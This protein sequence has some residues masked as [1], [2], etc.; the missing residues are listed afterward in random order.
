MEIQADRRIMMSDSEPSLSQ[1]KKR[2]RW[3][4]LVGV[5][6]YDDELSFA[7]LTVCVSDAIR[8]AEQLA[9][10]GF[11]R[12][13]I[14]LLTDQQ[15]PENWPVYEHIL[16]KLA[17][18]ADSTEEEDLLL[19]YFSGHGQLE[20]E[21]GDPYVIPRNGRGTILR[22]T[23]VAVQ[24][25]KELLLKARAKQKVIILDACHSGADDSRKAGGS[26][27]PGFIERV[28]TSAEGL[29][30]L[31]SC[32]GG[33]FSYE[34]SEKGCSVFTYYLLE[35]LRG[36][37][38][39]T[40]KGFVTVL[41]VNGYVVDGV[42]VWATKHSVSQTPRL[43]YL[44]EGDI[45]IAY[46]REQH[47]LSVFQPV[48][49]S[50]RTY[51]TSI[52]QVIVQAHALFGRASSPLPFECDQLWQAFQQVIVPAFSD[53]RLI[54]DIQFNSLEIKS[55]YI[56]NQVIRLTAAIQ[57]YEH[58]STQTKRRTIKR[59][60]STLLQEIE[61]ILSLLGVLGARNTA[62]EGAETAARDHSLE[63][64][65]QQ[66]PQNLAYLPADLAMRPE[67]HMEDPLERYN[68]VPLHALPLYTSEDKEVDAYISE[69]VRAL[70][71]LSE[72]RCDIYQMTSQENAFDFIRHFQ[73]IQ[74]SASA[75]TIRDVPG[76]FFWDNADGSE[77]IPFGEN[78][79]LADIRRILRVVF[80]YVKRSPTIE[81]V[82]RAKAELK[83]QTTSAD[84]EVA[85]EIRIAHA[86][87]GVL[88]RREQD[89]AETAIITALPEEYIAMESLLEYPQQCTM[90]GQGASHRYTLGSIPLTQG[91]KH[92]VV[93]ALLP[94][95]GIAPAA[96]S[97]SRLLEQ[98][99]RVRQLIVV[100]IAG[101]VPNPAAPSEHVR[102][103]DIV[104]SDQYGV[105][106][107]DLVKRSR[108]EVVY[109]PLPQP[110][111]AHLL[112]A[113]RYLQAEALKGQFP[114]LSSI[115]Q[116]LKLL[117]RTRPARVTDVL[118]DTDEPDR[119]IT[120]PRDPHRK[121]GQPRVFFGPIASA[122]T[123][124]RDAAL[125]DEL[126][127]R[128]GVK[129][130]EMEAAGVASASWDAGREYFVVRGICD[131]C[132]ERKNDLWQMYAAVGAA[133]YTCAL[134]ASIPVFLLA[135][136]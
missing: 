131:Y 36:H 29:A 82:T 85:T 106:S 74:Q 124:L 136:L 53:T 54:G 115:A 76:L 35:A 45:P 46:C 21:T 96:T 41:D 100:G 117:R 40:D 52:R 3:A 86:S 26:M 88:I 130:I 63:E 2:N 43:N 18:V 47:L 77:Y 103:G 14:H 37:A 67:E 98:F 108:Q 61:D 28:F 50:M 27:S 97:A 25:I 75:P 62:W 121:A 125:R 9:I 78:P 8:L 60:S 99:S 92:R 64:E 34:W 32:R 1:Q 70:D 48:F 24:D 59:A 101:G 51:C 129:A 56:V 38:D 30:I 17:A 81:S 89:E 118:F 4:V 20:A 72:N 68:S 133:A 102:L 134:L 135:L 12:R 7:Q 111:S 132:D 110:P 15:D 119:V 39:Q 79:G 69:H 23:A 11:D 123:L 104:V 66:T 126:R 84:R 94:G 42:K 114:W 55:R 22:R 109:R 107:Y 128:F 33:Q 31:S 87:G 112:L 122:S 73:V 71:S 16:A 105:I 5:N 6:R 57:E 93:L 13:H 83:G 113:A 19:F 58:T 10:G 44:V 80:D 91:G 65:E 90:P 127:D 116:S 120:H 95:T 49:V